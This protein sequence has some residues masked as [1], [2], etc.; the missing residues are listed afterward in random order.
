MVLNAIFL[1]GCALLEEAHPC[2]LDLPGAHV[3]QRL[4]LELEA[5]LFVELCRPLEGPKLLGSHDPEL[6]EDLTPLLITDGVQELV[7]QLPL[8]VP[9]LHTE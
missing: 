1:C 2:L 8:D 4:L 5:P 6:Q 3:L 9:L 7:D